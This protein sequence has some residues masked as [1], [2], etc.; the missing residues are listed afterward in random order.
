[1]STTL[2]RQQA[3]TAWP[4]TTAGKGPA[5][6]KRSAAERIGMKP[7]GVEAAIR[8]TKNGTARSAFPAPDG[9]AFDPEA[10]KN[11]MVPY[12]FERSVIAYGIAIGKLDRSGKLVGT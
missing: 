12:W 8:R 2:T 1:M 10:T 4:A 7:S 9:Y 5:L 3:L 11:V 6:N